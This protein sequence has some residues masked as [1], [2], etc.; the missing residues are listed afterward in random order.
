MTGFRP[1]DQIFTEESTQGTEVLI[2]EAERIGTAMAKAKVPQ[3]QFRAIFGTLRQIQRDWNEGDDPRPY[4]RRLQMLKPKL[5]YQARRVSEAA[6]IAEALTDPISMVGANWQ[7]FQ[8][9][10]D[11]V[12]A[13]L[14]YLVA[15]EPT[16][17]N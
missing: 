17:G 2:S 6:P 1:S 14:A 10:M 5:A 7:R 9:F 11:F 15:G 4:H 8:T 3:T 13:T 12:E 16:H